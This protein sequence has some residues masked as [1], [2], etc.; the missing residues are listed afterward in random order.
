MKQHAQ[1]FAAIC[2]AITFPL[3]AFAQDFNYDNVAQVQSDQFDADQSAAALIGHRAVAQGDVDVGNVLDVIHDEGMMVRGYI[4]DVGGFLG[5]DATPVFFPSN[6]ATVRI[7]GIAIE[8][9]LD[10][11]APDLREIARAD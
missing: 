5:I 9:V 1:T 2:V 11:G 8:L 7:D 10:I 3:S 4:V 6:R